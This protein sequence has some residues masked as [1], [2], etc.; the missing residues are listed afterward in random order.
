[1]KPTHKELIADGNRQKPPR[2]GRPTPSTTSSD[3]LTALDD[4]DDDLTTSASES[5]ANDDSSSNEGKQPIGIDVTS[6]SQ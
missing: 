3:A 1:M 4:I 2:S 6:Q 5:Y